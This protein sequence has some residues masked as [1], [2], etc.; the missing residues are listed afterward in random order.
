MPENRIPEVGDLFYFENDKTLK[1]I[2]VGSEIE[3]GS[4]IGRGV[5]LE[6][7]IWYDCF[8][9]DIWYDCFWSDKNQRFE[10]F[11]DDEDKE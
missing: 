5:L 4:Y 3:E 11:V 8:W 1:I 6:D 2:E 7:D 9:D 10:Y